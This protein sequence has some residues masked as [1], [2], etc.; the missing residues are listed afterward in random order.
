M[1][2]IIVGI[3]LAAVAL[4]VVWYF[5]KSPEPEPFKVR[6]TKAFFSLP[7]TLSSKAA[8]GLSVMVD[9]LDWMKA[10][11]E[12]ACGDTVMLN[13]QSEFA[14]ANREPYAIWMF[15]AVFRREEG[16][17]DDFAWNQFG[18]DWQVGVNKED[19]KGVQVAAGRYRVRFYLIKRTSDM[20]S[21]KLPEVYYVAE[22]QAI[23]HP[24]P[25]DPDCGIVPLAGEGNDRFPVETE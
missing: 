2:W 17:E 14:M 19:E 9:D 16:K 23:V 4:S 15:K 11:P 10:T 25:D 8:K 7:R 24:S 5:G 3:L 12:F 21:G 6:H 18:T 1:P 22:R 13:C 20:E